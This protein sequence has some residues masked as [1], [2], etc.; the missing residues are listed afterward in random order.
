MPKVPPFPIPHNGPH[1]GRV[2][3]RVFMCF[4][5]HGPLPSASRFIPQSQ[6]KTIV[7]Y[8]RMR[9]SYCTAVNIVI[10]VLLE[11]PPRR[12]PASPSVLGRG[13]RTSESN[14]WSMRSWREIQ[15]CVACLL[16]PKSKSVV[17][18]GIIR[19]IKIPDLG[20]PEDPNM[21][22]VATPPK[23]AKTATTSDPPQAGLN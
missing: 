18:L 20:Q 16:R 7:G 23:I 19:F 11:M 3:S 4:P 22:C 12:P 9:F 5:F 6:C 10:G 13:S 8:A 2:G 15:A 14:R 21:Q 17:R 1:P